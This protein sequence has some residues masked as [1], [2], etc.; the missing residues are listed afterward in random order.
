MRKKRKP[1]ALLLAKAPAVDSVC[2]ASVLQLTR[3]TMPLDSA[4]SDPADSALHFYAV[5]TEADAVGAASAEKGLYDQ[6]M[7]LQRFRHRVRLAITAQAKVQPVQHDDPVRLALLTDLRLG[8][9]LFIRLAVCA[10]GNNLRKTAL[11]L[12]Q[13]CED[14]LQELD[15]SGASH[16]VTTVR[17]L[18]RA[19]ATTAE[20]WALMVA[21][22]DIDDETAARAASFIDTLQEL[23][24]LPA[25]RTVAT[26]A[27][28]SDWFPPCARSLCAL[29][30]AF[31]PRVSSV[32][33]LH[34]APH[35]CLSD[36]VRVVVPLMPPGSPLRPPPELERDF[37]AAVGAC[38]AG[39]A[40]PLLSKDARTQVSMAALCLARQRW[41]ARGEWC[42][43][44]ATAATVSD[45][46]SGSSGILSSAARRISAVLSSITD[47]GGDG[48]S[49][50]DGSGGAEGGSSAESPDEVVQ[51]LVTALR[52]ASTVAAAAFARAAV[53]AIEPEVL[54]APLLAGRDGGA[55]GG[56]NLLCGAVAPV[57]LRGCEDTLPAS[58]LYSFQALEAW[59][60]RAEAC[61][62]SSHMD[63]DWWKEGPGEGGAQGYGDG[64]LRGLLSRATDLV[65]GTWE[66]PNKQVAAVAPR[67]F[68]RLVTLQQQ[69]EVTLTRVRL[70][71]AAM[72]PS[73]LQAQLVMQKSG[74]STKADS[75][76]APSLS[77]DMWQ[78]VVEQMLS[79]PAEQKGKYMALSTLLPRVGALRL[80]PLQPDLVERLLDAVGSHVGVASQAV[81]LLIQLLTAVCDE[82]CAQLA[83]DA[84][85]PAAAAAAAASAAAKLTAAAT[86][87]KKAAAQPQD[88]YERVR[89]AA[90]AQA[91]SCWTAA[92]AA[93]LTRRD[94]A[95]ARWQTADL[96]LPE[97][98]RYDPGAVVELCARIRERGGAFQADT[99]SGD[100][101]TPA[102]QPLSGPEIRI[103]AIIEVARRARDQA[104][105]VG[106]AIVSNPAAASPQGALLSYEEV[107][108]AALHY[109]ARLRL[110]ALGLLAC[111]ARTATLP[112]PH[113]LALLQETLPYSLKTAQ[114][115][116]QAVLTR[117]IQVLAAR[118]RDTSRGAVRDIEHAAATAAARA[119]IAAGSSGGSAAPPQDAQ[120]EPS[121][122]AAAHAELARASALT[123]WL[124]TTLLD[125]IYP[126]APFAREVLAGALLGALAAALA[127]PHPLAGAA[128]AVLLTPAASVAL[129][130]LSISSWDRSRRLAHVLLGHFPPP[131]ALPASSGGGGGGGGGGVANGLRLA[132]WG[133]LMTRSPRQRESDAGALILRLLLRSYACGRGWLVPLAAVEAAAA[134]A[135]TAAAD[136]APAAPAAAA[137]TPAAD[138][139]AGTAA[140]VQPALASPAA[141]AA[142]APAPDAQGAFGEPG[143]AG[144][145]AAH[146]VAGLVSVLTARLVGVRAA[147]ESLPGDG[148]GGLGAALSAFHLGATA[149][150]AG[151]GS[152]GGGGGGGGGVGLSLAHG[153]LA[154]LSY[155]VEDVDWAAAAADGARWRPIAADLL[156]AV[157]GAISLALLV[158]AERDEDDDSGITAVT[159]DG[160]VT[161]GGALKGRATVDCRGHRI[162]GGGGVGPA[163]VPGDASQE[164]TEVEGGAEAEHVVAGSWLIVKEAAR[165]LGALVARATRQLLS[166]SSGAAPLLSYDQ[167]RRLNILLHIRGAGQQ[168]ADAL[169]VLKHQ[170]AVAMAAAGFQAVCEALLCQRSAGAASGGARLED[171]AALAALPAAWM[172]ALLRRL[173]GSGQEVRRV[174]ALLLPLWRGTCLCVCAG[175]AGC[176]LV[177]RLRSVCLLLRRSG[178]FAAAFQA[179][180]RAEPRNCAPVLLPRAMARLLAL[181]RP[182]ADALPQRSAAAATGS[183]GA[184]SATASTLIH[185]AAAAAPATAVSGSAALAAAQ[186]PT[187]DVGS[188]G[189]G[190]AAAEAAWRA[191]VHSL[192][193]LRLAFIDS[194]L[195]RDVMPYVAPAMM[196]A[197]DAFEHPQFAV[198]NSG[199]MVLSAV[200]QRA[201]CNQKNDAGRDSTVTVQG[202][203]DL[204][205][206]MH[207]Y[208]LMQLAR[209]SAHAASGGLHPLLHPT[210]LL[211]SRLRPALHAGRQGAPQS[212]AEDA[213]SS[214][215]P[216][217]QRDGASAAQAASPYASDYAAP[218]V[219][220]VTATRGSSHC[221][222]SSASPRM[223]ECITC[224]SG[225][226]D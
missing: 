152:S 177:Q 108:C 13:V 114:G 131:L 215:R 49:A 96:F 222:S 115:E 160:S 148:V 50:S 147:Y 165:C 31:A 189:G 192:N 166:D 97:A 70:P 126:G 21:T 133:L 103:A 74:G 146:F 194:T 158:V 60:T 38:A 34:I 219:P 221:E 89:A 7:M 135:G 121:A 180:L 45:S 191:Q 117:S 141:A 63:Q 30:R 156:G 154:A 1:E 43:S 28:A 37:A 109:D 196:A 5:V 129:L 169:L 29:L 139:S 205:P 171:G 87:R 225:S 159:A 99:S 10:A 214:A 209:A 187:E 226:S 167:A 161:G 102:D 143:A 91:R 179:L 203:F 73:D 190:S 224:Y 176:G 211:L 55:A 201:I 80:L 128:A 206:A 140:V 185:S 111:D 181:A 94:S 137:A 98:L 14:G 162:L 112:P 71:V 62:R 66:S 26:A 217:P 18:L 186:A 119:K 88:P 81:Q 208:L 15:A 39:L 174:C 127:P 93:A 8:Y 6:I 51:V 23:L 83:R 3:E 57:L 85:P 42:E 79:Q 22:A 123:T 84:P 220:L 32:T 36:A 100:L 164:W 68:E 113:E 153:V 134:A 183:G 210:L 16:A 207:T 48:S 151:G 106:L 90:L 138:A 27:D 77:A 33:G 149:A 2:I 54:V 116:E 120:S 107:R 198:R 65:M 46:S 199:M 163:R 150:A 24:D 95:H 155:A 58:R 142:P 12:A 124:C 86:R 145:A 69:R 170:G 136:P 175:A 59:L 122:A 76:D 4:Q 92:A 223:P 44:A 67:V 200:I 118:I 17:S 172:D 202:F 184:S 25:G 41:R 105:A 104:L 212:D 193:V 218:F 125:G 213:S 197:I 157:Q 20:S 56:N 52:G 188:G 178:G 78:P 195:A 40:S 204:Y 75:G 9:E 168:L 216:Q 72:H 82:H 144:G 47:A 35:P 132:R 19:L 53:S 182:T 130:N 173:G 101:P 110:G 64:G 11:G 61:L